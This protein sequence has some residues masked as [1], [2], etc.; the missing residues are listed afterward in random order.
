VTPSRMRR[1]RI[2]D[3]VKNINDRKGFGKVVDFKN[4]GVWIS[5]HEHQRQGFSRWSDAGRLEYV[6]H[7]T[8]LSLTK[9]KEKDG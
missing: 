6:C 1:F 4:D 9:R 2:G 7:E 5:Y 3:Y 8:Q